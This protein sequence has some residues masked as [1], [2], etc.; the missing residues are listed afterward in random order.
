MTDFLLHSS[1]G[2]EL[3]RRAFLS[4]AGRLAFLIG[5]TGLTGI[6]LAASATAA[7][8]LAPGIWVTIDGDGL[9]TIVFPM[10]EMGQGSFTALPMILAEEM[11]AN[12][13]R[14][15][16]EQLDRDDRAYGNPLFGNLL[17]TA[18]S[19]AVMAYFDPLRK[20]GAQARKLLMQIAA[21][22][23]EVPVTSLS[24]EPHTVLH[25][26]SGRRLNYGEIAGLPGPPPPVP[27][28]TDAELKPRSAYRLIGRD[29]PRRDVPAKSR[30]TAEYAIDVQVPGMLYAAVLR[31]PV[32]GEAAL[33]VD[34]TEAR[35]IPG[36]V[37][38][39]TLPDGIAVVAERLEAAF[40]GRD[41]LS[42][43]WSET[44]PARSFDSEATLAAYEQAAG[45]PDRNAAIW[46]ESG[47]AAAAIAE[48]ERV[49][50]RTYLSDYAYH[51]QMEPMAAVASVDPD[52]K[53]AEVWAAT[54]TQTLTTRTITQVLETTPDR[55]RLHMLTMGG[56]FGR[57]TALM[58]EYVRD[59]L[60]AS[61]AVG[62]PV[63][64]VWT[65]E[66]D[67]KH[68]W[69]RPAAA[70]QLT[71]GLT[72]GGTLTGW[73]HRV[74]TP[75]VIAYFNPL[76][77]SQVEPHDIISMR[78]A[79]SKFYGIGDFLAEHVITERRARVIPWRAIGASYTSFAAEA[80][81]DELAE[82]AGADPIAFRLQLLA[83]NPRGRRLL[84]R[85]A[86]MAGWGGATG[87]ET[88][89]GVSFAG[90]G[91]SMAAGIAE[92]ALDRD[93]GRISVPHFWAAVDA[94]LIVSPDNAVAQIEGGIVYGLSS[95]LKERVTLAGGEVQQS[96]FYDYEILR[97]NEVP[98]ISVHLE[99]TDGPPTGIG[100]V[101]GPM[102]SAAVA[103]AFHALTGR[104][105]RHMPFTPDR[106]LAA[107]A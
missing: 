26:E 41:R 4:G 32:E 48:A 56:S 43:Q 82:E 107:L 54:Q 33:E 44:A 35:G 86:E 99:V 103:N 24:T 23:W 79:E 98:E 17:Y 89:L 19:S 85:V 37:R 2:P 50:Q 21:A 3:P 47:D 63:K 65:R 46:S 1:Q 105:L 38:T 25:P 87:G 64:V 66:D 104:R 61:K 70:Q 67:L 39:V 42:V 72:A 8:P 9:T 45:D 28:I 81:M 29:V 34:E 77:W 88:A 76:R 97:A 71:G 13:D 49:V 30:G 59:A 73:R 52:G 16:I 55:V 60:L 80:F 84:E 31:S 15:R 14:V 95:A 75:S 27:E 96:N 74:A 58:Q 36:V 93:S 101:G 94:G 11:D 100:E 69:F 7:A 106:V 57:R 83:D 92:V 68:G 10:T 91:D 102:T 5:A 62:R 90:Y 78:G 22:H 51:A 53:G 20:A 12:W 18:G 40:A 6:T